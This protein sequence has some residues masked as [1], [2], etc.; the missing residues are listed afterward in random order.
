ML[1]KYQLRN[2]FSV[3]TAQTITTTGSTLVGATKSIVIPINLDFF[4]IDYGDNINKFVE[5]E[6][7]K[8]VNPFFD[9]ETTKYI[10]P[11]STVGNDLTI[12]FR[13]W[14]GSS[15]GSEYTDA[16]FTET[17]VRIKKNGF[18]KSF[19]RLYFYD[20][21]SGDT[22]SLIFTEDLDIGETTKP[23][24][25]FNSL[26]WLRNDEFFI[27]NNTNRKVYME[28]RF[29]NAKTGK[30]LKFINLPSSVNLPLSIQDYSDPN[31]RDYRTFILEILNPKLNGG[32]YN[33]KPLNNSNSITL[34][35]LVMV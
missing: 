26:Y 1:I 13:F 5:E 21:N 15:L 19:F 31:N 32:Y 2:N 8:N 20:S 11:D 22:S 28:A 17:D 4:P 16:G 18:K 35:Q 30:V 10:F 3:T 33:F 23:K 6:V 7:K 9:T 29:F 24:I 25:I 12:N 27:K 34:S 14:N